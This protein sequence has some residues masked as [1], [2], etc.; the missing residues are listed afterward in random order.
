MNQ[1]KIQALAAEIAKDLKTPE[2]LNELSAMLTKITVEAALKAEM[3][4]H[5]GYEKHGLDGHHSGNSRNGYSAKKL[6]GDHGEIDLQTPRDRNSTFD[7]NL[8]V[9]DHDC[10]PIGTLEQFLVAQSKHILANVTPA[11][12]ME[13]AV[14]YA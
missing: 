3:N 7:G 6:K 1:K 2:D 8:A 13:A 14:S 9:A 12:R 4:H 11:S 10:D 5:L